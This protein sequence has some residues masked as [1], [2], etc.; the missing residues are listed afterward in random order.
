MA[1]DDAD[2]AAIAQ[3]IADSL[4]TSRSEFTTTLGSVV[5]SMRTFGEELKRVKAQVDSP[6]ESPPAESEALKLKADIEAL[7]QTLKERD[8][9]ATKADFASQVQSLIANTKD[10]R[11][12]SVARDLL[13]ARWGHLA[14][15]TET[16]FNLRF[17]DTEV[18]SLKDAYDHFLN[19]DDG[20]ALLV[21]TRAKGTD[22]TPKTPSP[23]VTAS[24][25]KPEEVSSL[26]MFAELLQRS[27]SEQLV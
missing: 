10:L 24:P 21:A 25:K 3:M 20:K 7:Q 8:A 14:Q 26:D 9:A 5:D 1:L 4:K 16:G 15:K 2:K 11:S 6:A 18:K 13:L 23:G 22:P 19:T 27:K 12:P 17:S